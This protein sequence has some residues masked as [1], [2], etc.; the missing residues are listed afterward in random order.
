MQSIDQRLRAFY[1]WYDLLL[2][3][4]LCLQTLL[5]S[6]AINLGIWI[7]SYVL[8]GLGLVA[9]R[10][11]LKQLPGRGLLVGLA[12]YCGV[13]FTIRGLLNTKGVDIDELILLL[14]FLKFLG[15]VPIVHTV[16]DMRR[17]KFYLWFFVIYF[18]GY[19]SIFYANFLELPYFLTG[20]GLIVLTGMVFAYRALLLR[21]ICL[22]IIVTVVFLIYQS[23]QFEM[24]ELYL[25][26]LIMFVIK[27]SGWAFFPLVLIGR[28][29]VERIELIRDLV[30]DLWGK[31]ET[32][33]EHVPDRV[34]ILS[35]LTGIG[36]SHAN[37]LVISWRLLLQTTGAIGVLWIILMLV[38]GAHSAFNNYI[39]T[40]LKLMKYTYWIGIGTIVYLALTLIGNRTSEL[41]TILPVM[42]FFIGLGLGQ[43]E[44]K[45]EDI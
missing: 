28:W 34:L 25:T 38:K 17:V 1:Q 3:A 37:E 19:L 32:L 43:Y 24:P 26:L 30:V 35:I 14:H 29:V 22:L 4:L 36:L 9:G 6:P 39:N 33:I 12:V 44:Q 8:W 23:K 11:S 20:F 13:T 41:L 5:Y 45:K 16:V 18:L 31:I 42:L 21:F 7:G 2:L 15:V 27:M 10:Y 40:T